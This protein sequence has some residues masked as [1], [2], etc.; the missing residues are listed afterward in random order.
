[1]EL[2]WGRVLDIGEHVEESQ[3]SR[4]PLSFT[5]GDHVSSE[6]YHSNCLDC[7]SNCALSTVRDV[8][9]P[10]CHRFFFWPMLALHLPVYIAGWL[11]V[12]ARFLTKHNEEEAKAQFKAILGGLG[13]GL[14]YGMVIRMVFK[15]VVHF[16]SEDRTIR[17]PK[18][19]STREWGVG[20]ESDRD[21]GRHRV[22]SLAE[23]TGNL[24]R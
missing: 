22:H 19:T 23:S 8:P 2:A 1:T 12:T 14:S 9:T 11:R 7:D 6:D 18:A 24:E 15:T 16:G 13:M 21:D 20:P 17:S 4:S 5:C 3:S 10:E